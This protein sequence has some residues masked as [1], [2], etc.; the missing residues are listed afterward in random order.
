M[1]IRSPFPIRM[2][3]LDL[4]GTLLRSDRSI[5]SR[6]LEA[7]HA[8]QAKGVEIVLASGRSVIA[9]ESTAAKFQFDPLHPYVFQRC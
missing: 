2:I 6:T 4:D 8:A 5:G 3:A 9:M 1:T 7:L